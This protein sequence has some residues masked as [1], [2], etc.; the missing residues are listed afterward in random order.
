[1][2]TIMDVKGGAVACGLALRGSPFWPYLCRLDD[3]SC[4][5]IAVFPGR[6]QVTSASRR[7]SKLV[8]RRFEIPALVGKKKSSSLVF[9]D[10][11]ADLMGQ[12]AC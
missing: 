11:A 6:L 3:E 9:A 5:V 2:Q 12:L 1:M 8:T 7:L 4:G 10:L